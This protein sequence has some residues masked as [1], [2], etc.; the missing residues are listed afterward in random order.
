MNS[1]ALDSKRRLS[2][3]QQSPLDQEAQCPAPAPVTS[4][5]DHL[6]ASRFNV[7]A[8][9]DDGRL[10]LWN[11]FSTAMAVFKAGD[12]NAITTLLQA[13]GVESEEE[14]IVRYLRDKGFLVPRGT[15]EYRKFLHAFGQQHYR[16]DRLELI[17]LSSEDCN[18][19]CTYCYEK[20]ARGTMRPD[21]RRGI[22]R[23]VED[24]VSHLGVLTCAWFG[25]EPLYGWP[26]IE[27]L[28]PFF[29]ETA[30]R[31][32]V[33]FGGSMTTNGYLLTPDIADKLLAWRINN[34]QITLDGKP[35]DHDCSRPT[36]DG[37][38]S[39]ATI[40]DNLKSM[41][42]RADPFLVSVRVNF[43][44][45]NI[46][47]MDEFMDL[48]AKEFRD[49]PRFK[50]DFHAVGRWG[51]DNDENISVCATDDKRALVQAMK[52][53]AFKRGLGINTIKD[54]NAIG[55]QVCYAARPYNF[56]IGASGKVMKCTVVLDTAENNIVGQLGEDGQLVL[57]QDNMALWTEPS[58]S[59]D[60]Q[61]QKCVALPTC[62]GISCPLPR[63]KE[64]TRPCV[65]TRTHGKD[66]LREMLQYTS[67]N[68]RTP[69]K[70]PGE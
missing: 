26:A 52:A 50:V 70:S 23:L 60:D 30:E 17:L 22:K 45:N 47:G 53:L 32:G 40:Y 68:K 31:Y 27:E 64:G 33:A 20:F 69:A 1:T 37:R 55:S 34:F 29:V 65:Q 41:A 38:G 42:R 62:Q 18:F 66:Q 2:V 19:R 44:P 59:R 54:A 7:R 9:T 63:I 35:S 10:I 13:S 8:T 16:S 25:G 56:I 11:T 49:D 36:R 39:F 12:V 58:F 46:D 43:S 5:R 24:R 51:G 21:V 57:N 4:R 61:C 15:D 6:V 67:F 3:L 48:L 14:G 28:G